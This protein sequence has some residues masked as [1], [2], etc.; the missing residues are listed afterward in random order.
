MRAVSDVAFIVGLLLLLVGAVR[1]I[2]ASGQ[3]GVL[4]GRRPGPAAAPGQVRR[5]RQPRGWSPWVLAG[6]GLVAVAA[7]A[8]ALSPS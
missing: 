5:V 8:A 2:G 3:L 6:A 7:L 4:R 1:T